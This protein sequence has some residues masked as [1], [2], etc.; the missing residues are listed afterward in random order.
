MPNADAIGAPTTSNGDF[1]HRSKFAAK[2]QL[3]RAA[4]PSEAVRPLP[5]VVTPT[6]RRWRR[7]SRF[8][9]KD[10]DMV[11]QQ[12]SIEQYRVDA[13]TRCDWKAYIT[14][15]AT[16]A[17]HLVFLKLLAHEIERSL[18]HKMHHDGVSMRMSA[19]WGLRLRSRLKS[20]LFA[21]E[22]AI[23]ADADAYTQCLNDIAGE[24]QFL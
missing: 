8:V 21:A 18:H 7:N 24:Y 9:R 17:N 4:P 22:L 10:V 13:R 14:T 12:A 5:F 3:P 16:T 20:T 15:R 11:D 1:D 23:T 2:K 19:L 6:F